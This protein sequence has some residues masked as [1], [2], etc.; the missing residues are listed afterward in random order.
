[1]FLAITVCDYFDPDALLREFAAHREYYFPTTAYSILGYYFFLLFS[2]WAESDSHVLYE[3]VWACNTAMSWTVVG[4]LTNRPLLTGMACAIVCVDQ[5]MWYIDITV[6]I[7]TGF[8]KFPVG[9]ARYIAWPETSL[10]KRLTAGHHL[11]FLPVMLYSL[12]LELPHYSFVAG[13]LILGTC[14]VTISRFT[15]PFHC[16]ILN[17]PSTKVK[18]DGEETN[19]FPYRVLY[20]NINTC[21]AFWKDVKFGFLHVVD[22]R[23]P[24]LM[25][26]FV[27]L[28]GN[29]TFNLVAYGIILQTIAFIKAL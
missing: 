1:M 28:A 24:W 20:L 18:V 29:V 8:K 21:Y 3:Q 15:T 12:D 7:F 22:H 9:V 27:T 16:L 26:P 19:H 11:W 17:T 2:R 10:M 14:L 6:A 4:M 13:A 5:L 25:I 23:S